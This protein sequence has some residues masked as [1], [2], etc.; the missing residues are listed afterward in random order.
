MMKM[1][2]EVKDRLG[3][4]SVAFHGAILVPVTNSPS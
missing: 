4:T 2:M 1:R 3:Y